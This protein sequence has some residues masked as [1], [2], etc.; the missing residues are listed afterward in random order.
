M[1]PCCGYDISTLDTAED[2]CT[3]CSECG[4]AWRLSDWPASLDSERFAAID[5][6]KDEKSGKRTLGLTKKDATLVA[7]PRLFGPRQVLDH[8]G[9]WVPIRPRRE[10]QQVRTGIVIHLLLWSICSGYFFIAFGDSPL[11]SVVGGGV[12]VLIP[13]VVVWLLVLSQRISVD[14]HIREHLEEGRCPSCLRAMPR[15]V[16]EVDG[17]VQCSGCGAAWKPLGY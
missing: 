4:A 5:E 9:R 17:C 11:E 7:E 16:D 2:G 3:V 1:C 14:E 13:M 8:R 10:R 15:E 12:T 6:S